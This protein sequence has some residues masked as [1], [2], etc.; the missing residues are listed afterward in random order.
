M[1][2]GP[3]RRCFRGQRLVGRPSPGH[4]AK[5]SCGAHAPS[6]TSPG[7]SWRMGPELIVEVVNAWGAAVALTICPDALLASP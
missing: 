7:P 6:T 5:G 2:R 4:G 1:V 3:P